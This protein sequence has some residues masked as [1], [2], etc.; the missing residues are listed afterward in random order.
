MKRQISEMEKFLNDYGLK[1]IG[2]EAQEQN[3]EQFNA[4][5]LQKDIDKGKDM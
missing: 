4:A 2:V 1:W 3:R 5:L